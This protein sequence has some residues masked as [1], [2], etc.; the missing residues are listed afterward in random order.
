LKSQFKSKKKLERKMLN[1]NTELNQTAGLA[2]FCYKSGKQFDNTGKID[3]SGLSFCLTNVK[4][5]DLLRFG[6]HF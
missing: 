1:K 5:G 2:G 6:K 3:L 4:A